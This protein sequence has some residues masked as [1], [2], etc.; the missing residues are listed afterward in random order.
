MWLCKKLNIHYAWLI[1]FT[2][3]CFFGASMGIYNNCAALYTASILSDMNWA[4]TTVSLIGATLTAARMAATSTTDKVFKKQPIK[5][6]LSLSVILMMGACMAK[7]FLANIPGYIAINIAIGIAGAFLL[8]V[9]VPLLINAWF[10][11][12]RETALGI[13]MLSSGLMAAICSPIFNRIIEAY[14]WRF[15]CIINGLVGLIVA[16]PPIWLFAVKT[17][18]ELGLK[19]YGWKEPEPMKV[20]TSPS[21]V[22]ENGHPDFDTRYSP[23]QKRK[24]FLL[25]MILSMLVCGLSGIPSRLPHFATTSGIGSAIGALMLS[26]SQFGNMA[27]KA[28]MGPLCDKFGPRKTYVSTLTLVFFSYLGFCFMPTGTFVLLLL[29]FLSG[30]SAGN[31]MMIYPKAVSTYSRGD[32]YAYYISRVSMAMTFFGTPF[33]LLISA[34]FDI[35]GGYFYIFVLNA[36]LEAVCILLAL[37]MFPKEA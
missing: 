2:C 18:E 6:V 30:L 5:P 37:K 10:V 29:A 19:P 36:A 28:L 26:V 27:G 35:T 34:I 13:A 1:L 32:E 17:P 11:E 14:G 9:P 31:N 21:Q 24:L 12:K 22:F 16:L 7:C 3:C 23:K 33:G 15:T 20:Y 8:Y 4:Y 25:S